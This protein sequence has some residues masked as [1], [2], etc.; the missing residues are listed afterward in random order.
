[1]TTDLL[2]R[3]LRDLRISVT[4]RCNMRCT[5]C[6]P[7]DVFGSDYP[8]LP[9]DE[10]LSFEEITRVVGVFT[11]LG[12]E[13]L[14]LTGGEPLLRKDLPE[15]IAMLRATGPELDIAMT[16]NGVLL[17]RHADALA[18]AG[19]DRVSVSLDAVDEETFGAITDSNATVAQV[20]EGVA[21]AEE[22][23]LGPVKIN[24][25]IVRGVNEDQ[26]LALADHFRGTPHIVR[27]I[28]FM[29][30]GVTNGWRLGQVVPAADIAAMI[31]DKYP[32]EPVGRSYS[33]EVAER[34]RYR[35]GAGELGIIA[36]VT[37]PFCGDCARARLSAD[38]QLF[39]CLFA[40]SGHDIKTPLRA[41]AADAELTALATD[42]W[43]KRD[44]RYSEQ[45]TQ[46]TIPISRVEMSYIG[47]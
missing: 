1:M 30:V 12:V 27:F 23:R 44:D 2:K 7:R 17:P 32:I 47:G 26:V 29:D 33:S 39:T 22:A 9:R 8:F 6:M 13:K 45:R 5:Y 40:A 21:A 14:R 15:L 24:A 18:E 35:D 16:T 3:P 25:V 20:L 28:E 43:T 11:E 19:L 36:S 31:N 34:W 10:L 42:I 4:D 41:G 46:T 37:R 38:G